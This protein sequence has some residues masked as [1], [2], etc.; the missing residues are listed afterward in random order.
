MLAPLIIEPD[1]DDRDCAVMKIDGQVEGRP[2]RFILDSGASR[3]RIVTGVDASSTL[4]HGTSTGLF[5]RADTRRGIASEIRVGT[6]TATGLEVD[7]VGQRESQPSLLGVDVLGSYSLLLDLDRSTV[8]FDEQPPYGLAW[9]TLRIGEHGH[10]NIELDWHEVTGRAVL[11][12]AAGMTVA[13]EAFV[14]AHPTLFTPAGVAS[15]T[16]AN[17]HRRQTPTYL[18]APCTVGGLR[19]GPHRVAMID[20]A[21][22]GATDTDLIVGYTTIGQANWCIDFPRHRWACWP[23]SLDS[24]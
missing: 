3:S 22:V 11:D 18:M 7:V 19:L 10:P 20:L 12:T 17:A 1:P 4:R 21:G 5:G 13:S 15:G 6:V 8:G 9:Q 14:T 23:R 16:D 24:G 2:V